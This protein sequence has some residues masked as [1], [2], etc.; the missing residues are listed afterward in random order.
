MDSADHRYR[1]L[2]D[3]LHQHGVAARITADPQPGDDEL[4]RL[5]RR[6]AEELGA[7]DLLP[8]VIDP[9]LLSKLRGAYQQ[10]RRPD[11]L[12]FDAVA[13][14]LS[15]LGVAS[16]IRHTG[17]GCATLYAGPRAPW[18]DAYG[19]RPFAALLCTRWRTRLCT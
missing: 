18:S 9:D 7:A 11:R 15:T 3:R 14:E 1:Q 8:A 19:E 17:D 5:A 4:I 12:D 2:L 10:G 16:V 6:I 13:R